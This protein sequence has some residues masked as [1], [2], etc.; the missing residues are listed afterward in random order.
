[1][2]HPLLICTP[3]ASEVDLKVISNS[4]KKKFS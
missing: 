3:E 2:R 4:L 1:M